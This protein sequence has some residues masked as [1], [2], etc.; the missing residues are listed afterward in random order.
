M[1]AVLPCIMKETYLIKSFFSH[2]LSLYFSD[3]LMQVADLKLC[4]NHLCSL[5]ML[6]TF[7]TENYL[8]KFLTLFLSFR[9]SNRTGKMQIFQ[10]LVKPTSE[11]FLTDMSIYL[12]MIIQTL[13]IS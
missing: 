11:P 7:T 1:D 12:T 9:L 8:P 10:Q 5:Y 3:S 13:D 6:T 2:I 4:K